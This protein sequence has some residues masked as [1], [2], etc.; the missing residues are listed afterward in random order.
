MQQRRTRT[1]QAI[2]VT[3][4]FSHNTDNYLP[5]SNMPNSGRAGRVITNS[6]ML[7][8]P[9][10]DVVE[11]GT[12]FI[13]VTDNDPLLAQQQVNE[14]AGYLWEH[15]EDFDGRLIEMDD[16]ID[17][18]LELAGPVCLL[19]MG[20]N[21]G[22]GSPADS[23]HLVARLHERKTPRSFACLFDPASAQ[24]AI[25][26]GVGATLS[27]RVGARTDALHGSPIDDEFTVRGV[28]E[29]FFEESQPRHGG[30]T[31]WDQGPSVV[32][33]NA[34]GLTLLI[35][36]VRTAPFSIHQLTCCELS[37][38]D[39]HILVAKGVQLP[40]AS[41]GPVCTRLIRVNT[42]GSTTADMMLL[43]F[44]RRRK[45]MFPFERDATWSTK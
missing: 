42:P 1:T 15:R 39:F 43:D 7:G 25:N 41:Y 9:Y 33:A 4:F 40:V 19:D 32:V 5:T 14:L 34:T 17:Q 21:V 16:A 45:P 3:N 10:A 8:F 37:P 44:K 6:I 13:S 29:G 26:A 31:S 11:M 36:S 20:D 28:Y 23:T 30:M 12:A 2:R 18:A 38:Q 35:N 24:Q 27:L 22:G